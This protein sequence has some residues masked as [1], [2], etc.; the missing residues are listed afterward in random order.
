MQAVHLQALLRIEGY[1]ASHL[2]HEL[3]PTLIQRVV[4]SLAYNPESYLPFGLPVPFLKNKVIDPEEIQKL[5][6]FYGFDEPPSKDMS[7]YLDVFFGEY[8]AKVGYLPQLFQVPLFGLFGSNATRYSPFASTSSKDRRQFQIATAFTYGTVAEAADLLQDEADLSAAVALY[9]VFKSSRL[10]LWAQV[11][12][13]VMTD[14]ERFSQVIRVALDEFKRF[15]FG[16]YLDEMI[17]YYG[18]ERTQTIHNIVKGNGILEVLAEKGDV[19]TLT[20]LRRSGV[21]L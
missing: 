19:G 3:T 12:I 15:Q 13:P 18:Q 20:R 17:F 7:R 5:Y 9:N 21:E 4:N 8:L 14:P 2:A 6:Q 11:V 10:D 1:E 16:P